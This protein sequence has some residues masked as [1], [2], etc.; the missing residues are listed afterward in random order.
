MSCMSSPGNLGA[1]RWFVAT[2][3]RTRITMAVPNPTFPPARLLFPA[4]TSFQ[5]TPVIA[6]HPLGSFT[7][8]LPWSSC[9]RSYVFLIIHLLISNYLLSSIFSGLPLF[10]Q[11]VF[12]AQ[13]SF[14]HGFFFLLVVYLESLWA[15]W[16]YRHVFHAGLPQGTITTLYYIN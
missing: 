16:S 13:A 2:S 12:T 10:I 14:G 6:E 1:P 3:P 5:C 4:G 8:Q 15:A 9:Y 11:H 7:K